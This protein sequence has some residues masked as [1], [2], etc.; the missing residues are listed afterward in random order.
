MKTSC[1]N[2][3]VIFAGVLTLS[4]LACNLFNIGEESAS[5]LAT[6][7]AQPTLPPTATMSGPDLTAVAE[8]A[9]NKTQVAEYTPTAVPPNITATGLQVTQV[10]GYI[11]TFESL[12]VVGLVH[13][14][15]DRTV[16]MIEVEIQVLN[17]GGNEIYT[18]KTF[19]AVDRLAPGEEA[20]FSLTVYE[21][22]G[23]AASSYVAYVVG[24]GTID[25]LKRT[26][27]QIKNM[28]MT[29][30][31]D[32]DIY[33]TGELVN[34]NNTPVIVNSM[35]AATFDS[36]SQILTANYQ[37]V[38]SRYLEPGE[39]GYFRISMSGPISGPGS[40]DTY[41]VYLDAEQSEPLER[42]SISINTTNDYVDLYGNYHLVG[43]A[44]NSGDTH[45]YVSL[46]A[47]VYNVQG[48]VVDAADFS[49]ALETLAPGETAPFDFTFW[50]P[51][52]Y[53]QDSVRTVESNNIIVD[54]AWTWSTE[55]GMTNLSTLEN[56]REDG[57]EALYFTGKLVNNTTGLVDSAV[58]VVFLRDYQ[59]GDIVAT[60]FDY[61]YEKLEPGATY[62]YA[63]EIP[64]WAG[65]DIDSVVVNYI[66]KGTKP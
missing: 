44:T 7:T 66:V 51:L 6:T 34:K 63:V 59:S 52:N 24:N 12:E 50:G 43:E 15:T 33:V 56:A 10:S 1:K 65:L 22:L 40:I 58:I 8:E 14:Q 46:V 19:T 16:D 28:Q 35:A 31:E 17:A 32:G 27:V 37:S 54:D 60:N 4:I 38:L 47:G 48:N 45:Y 20:P 29:T 36:A 39:S 49:L 57:D 55:T 41:T 5:S 2:R 53:N 25:D 13:N 64:L 42:A 3:F 62:E 9:E 21:D 61:D 18:D 26:E 11:N 30:D 23:G